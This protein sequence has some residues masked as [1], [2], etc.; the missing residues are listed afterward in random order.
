MPRS[1]RPINQL[2][3]LICYKTDFFTD[4]PALLNTLIISFCMDSEPGR[5]KKAWFL[6]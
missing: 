2:K 3:I 4:L 6:N 5:L 1:G